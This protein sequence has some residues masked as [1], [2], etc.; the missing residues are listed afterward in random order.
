MFM[1]NFVC[2]VFLLLSLIPWGVALALAEVGALEESMALVESQ[3]MQSES[4]FVD[5]LHGH[6]PEQVRTVSER[7]R[8]L[9]QRRIEIN[10]ELEAALQE[11]RRRES[12]ELLRER[13]EI[14]RRLQSIEP[15]VDEA[16]AAFDEDPTGRRG[17]RLRRLSVEELQLRDEL[18]A[19]QEAEE[20]N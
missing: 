20:T 8:M 5:A 13:P 17:A 7:L 14:T 11:R 4:D 3:I 16:A 6:D 1:A 2:S 15:Q 19:A 18:R 10:A 12:L 9:K